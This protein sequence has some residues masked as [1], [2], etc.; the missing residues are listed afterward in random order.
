MTVPC[1]T[2]RSHQ[3]EI[4]HCANS[5]SV[6]LH[7]QHWPI[8]TTTLN[9]S[10]RSLYSKDFLLSSSG[11]KPQSHFKIRAWKA[12]EDSWKQ[13][14]WTQLLT[15]QLEKRRIKGYKNE[16]EMSYTKT[17]STCYAWN[18][19]TSARG[20]GGRNTSDPVS[21]DQCRESTITISALRHSTEYDKHVSHCPERQVCVVSPVYV[22]RWMKR[23]GPDN[24]PGVDQTW[25]MWW[26]P[27]TRVTRA[28]SLG[29]RKIP[30]QPHPGCYHLGENWEK[31]RLVGGDT[32]PSGLYT[33]DSCPCNVGIT[34]NYYTS[35]NTNNWYWLLG[36]SPCVYYG[37][38]LCMI[39]VP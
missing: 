1:P 26:R 21:S 11:H 6:E 5:H 19:P 39:L 36:Q 18:K 34:R 16:T 7:S 17:T 13:I 9:A 28:L 27:Q 35:T 12:R 10:W 37:A 30:S 25:V 4:W 8:A 3:T 33:T 22:W 15:W 14:A 24:D 20:R 2:V 29:H 23:I 38:K 31:K 32:I